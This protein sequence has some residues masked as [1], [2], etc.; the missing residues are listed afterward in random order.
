MSIMADNYS[1]QR[2]QD[3]YVDL[4]IRR[5]G[6]EGKGFSS[7]P[8]NVMVQHSGHP[9]LLQKFSAERLSFF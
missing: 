4:S 2:P 9:S 8:I 7:R 3:I 6:K 5:G 1:I